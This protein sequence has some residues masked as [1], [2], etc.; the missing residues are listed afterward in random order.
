V[1]RAKLLIKLKYS[2]A[3]YLLHYKLL[4]KKLNTWDEYYHWNI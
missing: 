3:T 2:Y 4:T 1:Q